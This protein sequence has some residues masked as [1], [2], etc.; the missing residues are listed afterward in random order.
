MQR[1][2]RTLAAASALAFASLLAGCGDDVSIEPDPSIT[3]TPPSANL[4]V[5][6]TAQF[7]ATVVGLANKTVTWSSSD[8]A[9]ATVDNT[10]KV[11]AVA[12][13]SATIIAATSDA[14][15]KASAIVTITAVS[16]GV[17]K[18]EISPNADILGVGQTRQLTANVTRDPGIAGSVTWTSSNTA[19]ATI[20]TSGVVTAVTSGST[21]ITA[22]STVDPTVTGTAA[23]TVRPPQAATISIQKV[24]VTGNTNQ[25]VNFNNVAGGIDVTLNVDPGDQVLQRVEVLLDGAVVCTQNFSASQSHELSLA[26]VFDELEAVDVLCQINTAEFTQASGAV[27]FFNGVHQ[28]SARAIVQ[29]GT[30]SATPS[31]ALTFNN[32]SGFVASITNTNTNTGFPNSAVNPNTGQAWTQGT[33]VLTLAGVNYACGAALANGACPAG[34]STTYTNINVQL[35]GKNTAA[36]PAAGG[37]VYTIT[38]SGTTGWTASNTGLDNYQS[39]ETGELPVITAAALSN[40]QNGTTTLLNPPN[41]TNAALTPISLI[42]VDNVDPGA[43]PVNPVVPVVTAVAPTLPNPFPLWVTNTFTFAASTAAGTYYNQGVDSGVDSPTTAFYYIAAATLPGAANSCDLTGMT[44]IT[45]GSAVAETNVSTAYMLRA[46]TTDRLG[47]RVCRDVSTVG[48]GADFQVPSITASTGPANNSAFNTTPVTGV[49]YTVTDNASGFGATPVTVNTT[50]LNPDGTT[51]CV[52]GT[53]TASVT[54]TAVPTQA[55][56]F[57]PTAGTNGQGYY[58]QIASVRDQAGNI[59]ATTTTTFLVDVT[60]PSFTAGLS[61]PSLINGNAAA[62]FTSAASDNIDLN[63]VFGTVAYTAAGYSIQY[64]AQSLGSYGPPLEKTAPV[65]FTIA[66]F[67]RCM[68]AAGDFAST[69]NKAASILLSVTDQASNVGTLGPTAIPGANI[70]NCAAIAAP[71]VINTFTE[72]NAVVSI[73]RDN[74]TGNTL[75]QSVNLTAVADVAL[76][77]TSDPFQRVEFYWNNGGTLTLLGS[78]TGVLAQTPTTRTWTYTLANFNPA[79]PIPTGGTISIVALGV[80]AGGDAVPTAPNTNITVAP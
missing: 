65:N 6:Q 36:T 1:L 15:V 11:T 51:S 34:Q 20:S 53:T 25:T 27:K 37:Q 32:A 17:T 58:T 10:G 9:K 19:V 80:T 67:I 26:A 2:T 23:I 3:L 28:L 8:N 70:Q 77:S 47:N 66:Q 13:G 46:V 68:N 41:G 24:T 4:Q 74:P 69:T 7:S 45:S 59:T 73:S 33:H 35:F 22:A 64:P 62:S 78:A 38:Y 29:G 43:A 31:V 5:G 40:G 56:N 18:V 54:C 50:R 71:G 16:K 48:F 60:A 21:V 12:A 42:R 61:L 39:S 14:N 79:A 76:N 55:L 63:G 52:F 49:T 44:A 72:T 75:A 57:D 30:Q